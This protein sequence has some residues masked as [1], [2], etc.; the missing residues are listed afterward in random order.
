MRLRPIDVSL[1]EKR[2]EIRRIER[3]WRE[4]WKYSGRRHKNHSIIQQLI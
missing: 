1:E 4:I 3:D 2:E